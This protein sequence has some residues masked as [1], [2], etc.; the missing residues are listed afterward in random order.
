MGGPVS[1]DTR[2]VEVSNI[3]GIKYAHAR[4]YV[5]AI[6]SEYDNL[7][8]LL[9]ACRELKDKEEGAPRRKW[10]VLPK[11]AGGV[12]CILCGATAAADGKGS[13]IVL[14]HVDDCPENE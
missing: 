9:L 10:G 12:R 14:R 4:R 6:G 1:R 5:K 3:L 11:G 7:P 8:D 13:P 2:T